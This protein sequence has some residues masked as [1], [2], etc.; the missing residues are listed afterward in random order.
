MRGGKDLRGSERERAIA[1]FAR[2]LTE[3][4]WA[5]DAEDIGRLRRIGLSEL[6]IEH[7]ILVTASFNYYPRVADATGIDFDYE[8][9]LERIEVDRTREALPRFPVTDWNPAIDG[10]VLPTF[11]AAPQMAEKFVTWRNLHLERQ[12]PLGIATRRLILRV[13]AEE[14]CDSAALGAWKDARSANESDDL[15]ANFAR[16]ITRTPWAMNHDD[17]ETLRKAGL[18]DETILAAITLVAHQNAISRM[19]HGLAAM[20]T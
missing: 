9:P 14:L 4:P 13:V 1:G 7:A 6:D 17:A 11:V 5:V 15:L 18:S 8:S 3:V 16:K 2:L 10:S 19:H 12:T 20:R